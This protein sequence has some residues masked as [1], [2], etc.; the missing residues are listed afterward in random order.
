MADNI[1]S[2]SNINT[3]SFLNPQVWASDILYANTPNF[4]FMQLSEKAIEA[5]GHTIK[6]AVVGT[7]N[8]GG[9]LHEGTQIAPGTLSIAQIT[10]SPQ[11]YGNSLTWSRVQDILS[12]VN[13]RDNV[14]Y[15]ELRRD[16]AQTFD[17]VAY[18]LLKA[19]TYYVGGGTFG[20][21]NPA[22]W[23]GT[24][25]AA[26]YRIDSGVLH[27]AGLQ[28]KL[29][30]VP[31]FDSGN[32]VAVLHPMQIVHL[33]QDGTFREAMNYGSPAKSLQGA[34]TEKGLYGWR[35]TY[36]GLDIL[37]TTQVSTTALTFGT[38]GT[39]TAYQGVA[40]GKE[41]LG[42]GWNVP[43]EIN[44]DNGEARNAFRNKTLNWYSYGLIKV[45]KSEN[46]LQI[47][48]A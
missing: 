7:L 1:N 3:G 42:D 12:I 44:Y 37:E 40:M 33:F 35:A 23:G 29:R 18:A 46:W 31:V 41:A 10:G 32:Y 38:S 34:T 25:G 27:T 26:D 14:G 24:L 6:W 19:G 13:M 47:R 15:K 43:L 17:K 2:V 21:A 36:A 11:E 20:T 4:V 28:L 39:V 22:V 30:N 16:Y 45:L 48:T 9:T 8:P 5:D